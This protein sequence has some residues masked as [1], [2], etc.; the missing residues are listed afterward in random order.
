MATRKNVGL[1]TGG[2]MMA[3]GRMMSDRVLLSCG[4]LS[5]WL[6]C[7]WLSMSAAL[8][9][10]DGSP[11]PAPDYTVARSWRVGGAA[12]WDGMALEGSGARLF[13]TREDHVDVIETL[14]GRPAGSIPHTPG[15]RGVA[16]A[17]GL[18]RGFT[19]NSRSNTITVFELDSLRVIQEVPVSGAAPDSIVYEPQHD[20]IITGNRES[21]DL[22]VLDAGTLRVVSSVPLPGPPEST[23]TDRTGHI[24]VNID[25]APGKMAL[26]DVKTL[27]V[28]ARW[29][30]K[31]CA[32]PTGLAIDIQGH[33]LF[34][35][36]ANQILA[37]TDSVSG[38][39][40]ARVVIGRGPDGV[41]YDPDLG[42]LFIANG[43]DGTLTVIRQD[44]PDDYR[45]LETVTTQVSARTLALDPASHRI[46][47]AAAQFGPRPE[48]AADQPPPPPNVLPDSFIVLVAQPK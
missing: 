46:Y 6:L 40:I 3:R 45:V 36:C 14:S 13:I 10:S 41:A 47:L 33:R 7:S 25:S 19:S 24:Y 8:A 18:K 26:V 17:P 16:F 28:K 42:M 35:A 37:V 21:A 12:G 38:K 4:L 1:R 43:I 32:N 15:V 44:S 2:R 48:A 27:T 23:V 20:Y 39:A 30:L 34:S 11:L 9:Q 29:P 5:C 31:D 22:S